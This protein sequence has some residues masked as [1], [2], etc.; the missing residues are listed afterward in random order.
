[1]ARSPRPNFPL[2]YCPPSPPRVFKVDF[3]ASQGCT[4]EILVAIGIRTPPEPVWM[5]N[6]I[7]LTDCVSVKNSW[8]LSTISVLSEEYCAW[9]FWIDWPESKR[10]SRASELMSAY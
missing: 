10:V 2:G 1:M 8:L 6:P 5:L 4:S 3:K 9:T 7:W